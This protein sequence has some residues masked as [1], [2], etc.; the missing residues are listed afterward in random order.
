MIHDNTITGQRFLRR[1]IF[2]VPVIAILIVAAL[3]RFTPLREIASPEKLLA[4]MRADWTEHWWTVFL[5][6]AVY[7]IA[8]LALFPNLLLNIAVI[9]GVGGFIGWLYAIC[10]SLSAATVFFL[11]GRFWGAE[12]LTASNYEAIPKI[13]KFMAKGGVAAVVAV[14]A[15][16]SG[17]YAVV[18]SIIGTFDIKYRDFIVGTF[19]AHLPG[20]LCLALF[21]KQ[22]KNL[23]DNPS[24]QNIL[25]LLLL[26]CA[27]AALI[28]V[29]RRRL[30]AHVGGDPGLDNLEPCS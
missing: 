8:N 29:L 24:P 2:I 6:I 13:K 28:F 11:A 4:I 26:V 7:I 17:P 30:K 12:K 5:V 23:F 1:L 3:W 9:L 10:G 15:V 16:P 25:I 21:G 14:H 22:L 19:I 20:T 27:A 18:N